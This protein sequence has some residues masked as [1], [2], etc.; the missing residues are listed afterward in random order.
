M[1]TIVQNL[2]KDQ[3]TII[4]LFYEGGNYQVTGDDSMRFRK[5]TGVALEA[6]KTFSESHPNALPQ[7]KEVQKKLYSFLISVV[8]LTVRSDLDKDMHLMYTIAYIAAGFVFMAGGIVGGVL[9]GRP[10]FA[11]PIGG[12]LLI[13]GIALYMY[14]R[15]KAEPKEKQKLLSSL[16]ATFANLRG[17]QD[18]NPVTAELQALQTLNIIN[19]EGYARVQELI[20]WIKALPPIGAED[21]EVR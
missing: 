6:I 8:T 14:H 18:W 16:S 3:E 13:F 20:E 19:Q 9:S 1:A 5:T 15:I 4:P 17:I 12:G 2:N 11:L 21:R 10:L 7:S